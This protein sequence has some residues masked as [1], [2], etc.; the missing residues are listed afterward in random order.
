MQND[1][2]QS[3][4]KQQ[5]TDLGSLSKN[6]QYSDTPYNAMFLHLLASIGINKQNT[7]PEIGA[8][9]SGEDWGIPSGVDA[10]AI[11]WRTIMAA[12]PTLSQ[13]DAMKLEG[14]YQYPTRATTWGTSDAYLRGHEQ[15]HVDDSMANMS[16]RYPEG[17]YPVYKGV[18]NR[19]YMPTDSKT[20][21][22]SKT[23]RWLELNY[24]PEQ[25]PQERKA[26]QMGFD[27]QALAAIIS[28]YR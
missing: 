5:A 10:Q 27:E 9:V 28:S 14:A 3:N 13:E 12:N 21:T 7:I 4:F 26:E 19:G 23:E 16:L 8:M 25:R 24:P 6:R 11:D 17:M 2:G 20:Q 1:Y 15:S 22:P 18:G